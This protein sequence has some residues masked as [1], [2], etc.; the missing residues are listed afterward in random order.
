[1]V[2]SFIEIKDERL[3]NG[4]LKLTQ[5]KLLYKLFKTWEITERHLSE[6]AVCFVEADG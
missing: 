4:D 3:V 2:D 1:M 6:Q 5:P